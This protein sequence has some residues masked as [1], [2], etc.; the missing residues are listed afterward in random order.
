MGA[1]PADDSPYA[2]YKAMRSLC[3]RTTPCTPRYGGSFLINCL[4]L[5]LSRDG[6]L[7]C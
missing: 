3:L 7:Q 1:S 5:S 2:V 4:S 6:C